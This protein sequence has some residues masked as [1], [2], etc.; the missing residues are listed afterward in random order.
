M[1]AFGFDHDRPDDG[2]DR[3]R[4]ARERLPGM[5]SIRPLVGRR[6]RLLDAFEGCR[7]R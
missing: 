7:T 6:Q 5:T 1:N 3:D 4:R 2:A